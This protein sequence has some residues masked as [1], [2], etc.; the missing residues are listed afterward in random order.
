MR[1]QRLNLAELARQANVSRATLYYI[2]DGRTPTPETIRQIARGLAT[3]PFDTDVID[4]ALETRFYGELMAAAH[5]GS[6]SNDASPD[7]LALADQ[8]PIEV[9]I[10]DLLKQI[11]GASIALTNLARGAHDWDDDDREFVLGR[12]RRLAERYG[13]PGPAC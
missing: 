3:D 7:V 1:S 10:A 4:G 12:L 2:R 11:P 8:P 6:T 13:Q 5:F 9:E